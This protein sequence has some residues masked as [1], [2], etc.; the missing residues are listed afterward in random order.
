MGLD[1]KVYK[2]GIVL[3]RISSAKN[4][5]ISADDYSHQDESMK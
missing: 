3:N 1:D 4:S 5:L 2:P